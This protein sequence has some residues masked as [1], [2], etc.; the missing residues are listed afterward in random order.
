[1][2]W[3]SMNCMNQFLQTRPHTD[4]I[5]EDEPDEEGEG[6][7]ED[8]DNDNSNTSTIIMDDKMEV[9]A[10]LTKSQ[11]SLVAS[12]KATI[13]FTEALSISTSSPALSA[14]ASATTQP[15]TP[16]TP[17]AGPSTFSSPAASP[18][19]SLV[20]PGLRAGALGSP[21]QPLLSPPLRGKEASGAKRHRRSSS[22]TSQEGY[23]VKVS[24]RHS[25]CLNYL[26]SSKFCLVTFCEPSSLYGCEILC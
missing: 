18:A 22:T 7:D 12:P 17:N 16:T 8:N 6:D 19:H 20:S 13:P 24:T 9:D 3:C 21:H 14:S 10:D 25:G 23:I 26:Q 15:G 11:M 4:D 2:T 1:M 5:D